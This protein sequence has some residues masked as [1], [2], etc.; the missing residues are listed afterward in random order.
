MAAKEKKQVSPAA[1]VLLPADTKK[2]SL[3]LWLARNAGWL[4]EASLSE[5]Q[6]T[7]VEAHGFKATARCA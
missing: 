1:A 4:R 5:A 2:K 6:R 3:P 7:W